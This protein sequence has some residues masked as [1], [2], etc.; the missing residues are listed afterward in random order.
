MSNPDLL[1]ME[2][3]HA[4]TKLK[5][6]YPLYKWNIIKYELPDSFLKNYTTS[7]IQR[8]V[9]QRSINEV[10]L[11]LVVCDFQEKPHES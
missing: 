6:H 10:T 5:D 1:G 2:L 9:R 4:L 7:S 3:E 8:I 11:E